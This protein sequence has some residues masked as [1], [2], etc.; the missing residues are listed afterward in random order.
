VA[1]FEHHLEQAKGFYETGMKPRYDVTKA[2]VDLGKAQLSLVEASSN[3][4]TAKAS[5]ANAMGVDQAEAFE[6]APSGLDILQD[7]G[8][9]EPW[10]LALENRLDYKASEL[11]ITAGRASLSAE[12]RSSSP[13]ISLTGGYSGSGDDIANLDKGWNTGLRMSVP[14]VDGGLAKAKVDIAR[15]QLKS[16]EAENEKLKQDIMLDVSKALTDITKARER[17][18]IANLTLT[19][20]EE[21]RKMAV[22]R[23]ETGVGD[24]LE[25]TDALLSFTDAQM[26]SKQAQ[27]DLQIAIISLE[28][29]AGVEFDR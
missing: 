22:G 21:N 19:S 28:R 2:E 8:S 18:R 25:V 15:A 13:T 20:A 16:L 12:A 3:V 23:Y 9:E 11:K 29:A 24:P 10:R 4:K 17:I 1:A 27:Y 26:T 7:S 14:I 6:I 5:L